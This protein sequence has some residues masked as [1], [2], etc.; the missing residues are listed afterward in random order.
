MTLSIDAKDLAILQ[1]LD[2]NVR[3]SYAQIGRKTR[4]SKEVVQYRIKNLE[5]RRI[6][7]GY[8]AIPHIGTI[9][10]VYKLLIKNKSL[11]VKKKEFIEFALSQKAV[12]WFATTEGNWDF[13]ISSYVSDDT[14]FSEFV[15]E[16]MKRFG[17]YFKEK[18]ILKSTSMILMN[19]KYLY[20]DKKL[21]KSKEDSFLATENKPD[22]VD[23]E[24]IRL[25]ANNARISFSEIGRKINLTSEA[26]SARYRNIIKKELIKGMNPRI[27]QELLGYSYY[28]IFISVSDYEKKDAI[29]KYYIQHP[30]CVFIMKHIGFYDIH[31]ELVL[32]SDEVG[33]FID[34]LT[35]KFGNYISAYEP[36]RIRKE[37]IMVVLR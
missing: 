10:H 7:T 29:C 30:N 31:L 27:N 34:D 17:K 19:E 32:T 18:H 16:L 3:S 6:I 8:W 33:L 36:L 5:K 11:G 37:H 15:I 1:A 25:L 20:K 9:N 13:V 2:Q 22:K 12:S 24:I 28:H 26:V 23:T 14:T 21:I 35:E 4:L